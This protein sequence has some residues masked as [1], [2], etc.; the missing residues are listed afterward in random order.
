MNEHFYTTTVKCENCG[1]E[2]YYDIPKGDDI[3]R[4]IGADQCEKCDCEI[5][6]KTNTRRR[7]K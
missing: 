1:D 4:F 7:K 6:I 3:W 5:L 2:R